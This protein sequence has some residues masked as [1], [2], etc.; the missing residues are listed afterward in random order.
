MKKILFTLSFIVCMCLGWHG[1]GRCEIKKV[2]IPDVDI[3]PSLKSVMSQRDSILQKEAV[4]LPAET[5]SI[6]TNGYAIAEGNVIVDSLVQPK[7]VFY[8]NYNEGSGDAFQS[9]NVDTVILEC[10]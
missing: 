7:C 10:Q 8:G 3:A 4:T 1:N 2:S 9:I 6:K 5:S